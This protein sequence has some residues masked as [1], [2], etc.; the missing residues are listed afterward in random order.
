MARAK[1]PKPPRVV[2]VEPEAVDVPDAESPPKKLV[3]RDHDPPE[4]SWPDDVCGAQAVS[5]DGGAA[6]PG[7]FGAQFSR[8]ISAYHPSGHLDRR[9]NPQKQK[10]R[11]LRRGS[12]REE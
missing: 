4:P 10:P 1:P 6:I 5:G 8:G 11:H 3:P 7:L 2:S 12:V 9:F